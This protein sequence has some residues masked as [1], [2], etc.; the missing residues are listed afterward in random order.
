MEAAP[1]S[2]FRDYQ[3]FADA[4]LSTNRI[5]DPWL[6]GKERFRLEPVLLSQHQYLRLSEAAERIGALYDELCAII[7]NTPSYL[8]FFNLTPYQRLMWFAS[9]GEW[10]GI[11][12][13]DLF[14]LSDGS[15]RTC[16]M[17]SD[18]PSGEA[19]AVL[20]NE[21]LYPP[22]K[23]L[24]F[25]PNS[26]FEQRFCSMIQ[27]FTTE[28]ATNYKI[29]IGIV[30]PTEQPEDLSM[31]LCYEEWLT[32]A[33]CEVVR[34]APYNLHLLKDGSAAMFGEKIDILLRHYKTD[35]WAERESVWL[36]GEPFPDPDPLHRELSVA[37]E[38][39]SNGHLRIVNPFGAVLTQNK[40]TMAFVHTFSY[41]FSEAAQETIQYYIPKTHR[42]C[43][44]QQ[45][46]EWNTVM[47]EPERFVLKSDYG[48]EGDEVII[49]RGVSLELWQR[50]LEQAIP[51]RWIVQEFFEA[52][53]SND[54]F[55]PNYGV[56][57]L[58]GKASGIYTRLA[59]LQTDYRALSAATFVQ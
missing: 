9:G 4:L 11:A 40:L 19:E 1:I 51:T 59:P 23:T 39:S 26:E 29:R 7:L 45:S 32:R 41:L 44:I 30:F 31:I 50:S 49:G 16:E 46:N 53:P 54:G 13:L 42:L 33:G 27:S 58:G 20:L 14:L 17:N 22:H 6:D 55:L 52:A 2:H 3:T 25:N 5:S 47:N 35:W 38:A 8:D 37:L 28:E 57:L 36:D 15:I 10:H 18:T 48:C 34:G 43:D 12:R 21:I 56:Y 24:Y